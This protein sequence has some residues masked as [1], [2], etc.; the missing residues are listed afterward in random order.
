MIQECL[1]CFTPVVK[2]LCKK[3]KR[4]YTHQAAL[5]FQRKKKRGFL[6]PVNSKKCE[7]LFFRSLFSGLGNKKNV[8]CAFCTR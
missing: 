8:R 5:E 6:F 3:K 7:L 4:H 2:K 1:S